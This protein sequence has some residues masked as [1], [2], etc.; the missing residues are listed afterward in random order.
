MEAALKP[1]AISCKEKKRANKVKV[2]SRKIRP[3]AHVAACNTGRAFITELSGE[4]LGVLAL[5]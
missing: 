2:A 4:G 5:Q 1:Q 3:R